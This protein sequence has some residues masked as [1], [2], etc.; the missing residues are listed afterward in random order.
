[1]Q[2]QLREMLERLEAM[3]VELAN[4]PASDP[5]YEA[6]S[7]SE[8]AITSGMFCLKTALEAMELDQGVK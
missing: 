4:V 8:E 2:Q 6:A 3:T 5:G 7:Y 1:M